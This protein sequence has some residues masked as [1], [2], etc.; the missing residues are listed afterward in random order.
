[1]PSV[2]RKVFEALDEWTFLARI[3]RGLSVVRGNNH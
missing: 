1:M 3:Y 2:T